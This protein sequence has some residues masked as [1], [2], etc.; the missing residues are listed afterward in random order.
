METTLTLTKAAIQAALV[1]IPK[2]QGAGLRDSVHFYAASGCAMITDGSL[3]LIRKLPES[4]QPAVDFSVAL[5]DLA[6]FKAEK[7]VYLTV[8]HEARTVEIQ[9][10]TGVRRTSRLD[11]CK[12][13]N[14]QR[15]ISRDSV[16][17]WH[18]VSGK[19]AAA[20]DKI[21]RLYGSTVVLRPTAA[22]SVNIF[23]SDR[24]LFG[25]VMPLR[26]PSGKHAVSTDVPDWIPMRPEK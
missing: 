4:Q 20:I 9:G 21:A 10:Y 8:A 11:E 7:E 2:P 25:V 22:G 14:F 12:V 16:D 5:C 1:V 15:A 17:Q 3:M 18:M 23:F 6:S 13:P 19:Y 24:D 26:E